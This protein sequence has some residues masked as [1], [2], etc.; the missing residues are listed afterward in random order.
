MNF[1]PEWYNRLMI[2]KKKTFVAHVRRDHEV[3]SSGDKDMDVYK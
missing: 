2:G 3:W 1:I